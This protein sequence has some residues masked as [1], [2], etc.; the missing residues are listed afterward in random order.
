MI[1]IERMRDCT[2]SWSEGT[3]GG[4][5]RLGDGREKTRFVRGERIVPVG[6]RVRRRGEGGGKGGGIAEMKMKI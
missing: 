2:E 4:V 1:Y 6:G 3:K 5:K